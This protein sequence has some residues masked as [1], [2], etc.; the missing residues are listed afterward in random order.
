M[1]KLVSMSKTTL[2]KPNGEKFVTV[3]PNLIVDS[4]F[5]FIANAMGLSSGRPDVLSHIAIGSGTTAATAADTTLESEL[6]RVACTYAH[7]AGTKVLTFTSTF[8]AG[9]GTGAIT[10]AALFNDATTGDMYDRV[11]FAVKNKEADDVLVQQFII[12]LSE[13]AP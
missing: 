11:V 6:A 2:I 1:L 12:T 3:R 7:T 13:Q 8:G 10:E 4:G 5:D 9:I